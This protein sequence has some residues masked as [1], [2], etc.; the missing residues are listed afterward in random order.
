L[1]VAD[2]RR[3]IR[4]AMVGSYDQ[5]LKRY[6]EYA[7]IYDRRFARYSAATL[8]RSLESVLQ[9]APVAEAEIL[10]VA[11]GT[12]LFASMVR[13]ARPGVCMTGADVS[14]AMLNRFNERF[15]GDAMVK[16]VHS[17]AENLPFDSDAFD[18]VTCNNAFHLIADAPGALREFR[19]ALKPGGHVVIV[20]W[21]RD[22]LTI[23]ALH[24]SLRLFGKHR[25]TI[26]T[27]DEMLHIVHGAGLAVVESL[28]FKATPFWGMMRL[29]LRK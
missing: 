17:P 16:S 21:C 20:D 3:R 28:R 27:L 8:S 14:A 22:Y 5:L 2:S 19:R 4:V 10:D 29:V 15:A 25:R 18:I 24:V 1:T 7:P 13:R 9:L 23:R 26:R 11:C 12:G 6:T